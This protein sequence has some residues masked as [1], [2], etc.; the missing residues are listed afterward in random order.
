LRPCIVIASGAWGSQLLTLEHVVHDARSLRVTLGD[1]GAIVGQVF[2]SDA[3]LDL[4]L[5]ET[6]AADVAVVRLGSSA[7]LE[8]GTTIGIVGFPIPDAFEEEGLGVGPSVFSGRIAGLRKGALELD[9]PVIPGESGGPV[10]DGETGAVIGLAESRFEEERA[11][12]F[13]IPIDD[14]KRFLSRTKVARYVPGR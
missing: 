12:G 5:I 13:A 2:A 9:I 7:Q 14:A 6:S 8:P 10:F 3:K 4:A 11:I 1:R